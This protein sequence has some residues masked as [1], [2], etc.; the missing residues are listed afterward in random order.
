MKT[1]TKELT[2][3]LGFAGWGGISRSRRKGKETAFKAE[4]KA[5]AKA[6][7]DKMI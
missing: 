1:F 5:Y 4:G 6:R 7:S 3:K 2:V